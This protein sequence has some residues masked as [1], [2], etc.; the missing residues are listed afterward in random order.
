MSDAKSAGGLGFL[1]AAAVTALVLGMRLEPQPFEK[2]R[3]QER[4]SDATRRV[5]AGIEARLWEDPFAAVR[6]EDGRLAAGCEKAKMISAWCGLAGVPLNNAELLP[7][8]SSV[9]AA[10]HLLLFATMQGGQFL[11]AEEMRRR[12]RFAVL[13]GLQSAAYIPA[14]SGRVQLFKVLMASL[15]DTAPAPSTP[16]GSDE[17]GFLRVPYEHWLLDELHPSQ[18]LAPGRYRTITVFW[19]DENKLPVPRKLDALASL[20]GQVRGRLGARCDLEPASEP[21]SPSCAPRLAYWPHIALLGPSNTDA[22]Q[23]ALRDLKIRAAEGTIDDVQRKVQRAEKAASDALVALENSAAQSSDAAATQIGKTS[24]KQ[25]EAMLRKAMVEGSQQTPLYRRHLGLRRLQE[26]THVGYQLLVGA[27][28]FNAGATVQHDLVPEIGDTDD[29][30]GLVHKHLA[31]VAKQAK[32]LDA[33]L[34]TKEESNVVQPKG[35][36]QLT[37]TIATDDRL[38]KLLVQ[39]LHARIDLGKRRVVLLTERDSQYGRALAY[40]FERCLLGQSP[41]QEAGKVQPGVSPPVKVHFFR[42]LDGVTGREQGGA[43]PAAREAIKGDAPLIEWPESTAQLDYLRRV[44]QSLRASELE[45][46]KAPIGAIGVLGSDVHDKLLILQA[47][48]DSYPDKVF[49]T[50]DMDARL[51]HPQALSFTRN[52]VVASSLPLLLPERVTVR[53]PDMRMEVSLGEGVPPLRDVYQSAAYLA[54]RAASC[55]EQSCR[56]RERAALQQLLDAPALYEVGRSRAVQLDS[57]GRELQ[58]GGERFSQRLVSA[59]LLALSAVAWLWWPSTPSLRQL[60]RH[61]RNGRVQSLPDAFGRFMVVL[62]GG[63]LIYVLGTMVEFLHPGRL[64]YNLLVLACLAVMLCLA[65]WLRLRARQ[66]RAQTPA[67]VPRDAIA[68]ALLVI[69]V[70]TLALWQATGGEGCYQCEPVA[71]LEGVSA[72]PSHWLHSFALVVCL[73]ALD[74]VWHEGWRGLLR[75]QRWLHLRVAFAPH[76]G[77]STGAVAKL[78]QLSLLE[79]MRLGLLPWRP[80]ERDSRE[81][82]EAWHV[83]RLR[84]S[85][86]PRLGRLLLLYLLTLSLS[87]LAF[88][89]FSE[90]L[91]PEVPVRGADH[92]RLVSTTLYLVLLL[93]P[94]LVVAVADGTGLVRQLIAHLGQGRSI[95]P[96][97]CR[98]HFVS[99]L[100]HRH[101][102]LWLRGFHADPRE[103]ELVPDAPTAPDSGHRHTLLDDWID[104]QLVARSSARAAPLVLGPFIVLA[105][106]VLARSRVFDNWALT[107]V[108][109]VTVGVYLLWLIAVSLGLRNAAERERE[110]AL[111]S[112]QAD[113]LWL[114]GSGGRWAELIPSFEAMMQQVR[115]T[116]VGAFANVLDQPLLKAALL[117]VAGAGLSKL[118]DSLLLAQ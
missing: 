17:D 65:L 63:A 11:G 67:T 38:V 56:V 55:S 84:S 46:G 77:T 76:Q 79:T 33:V 110:N 99:A 39:E 106:M 89:L 58:L 3:P 48:H 66:S 4:V 105:L 51:L 93:F 64:N 116:R 12:M 94:L 75:D 28:F 90:G 91:M 104:I 43:T 81:V 9:D 49:F 85:G 53:N 98:E 30:S 7:D 18:H 59:L 72:W 108:I 16:I 32:R 14:D 13:S 27:R 22:L 78:R 103:R 40:S 95:Y 69:C 97:K 82:V 1:A 50:T 83:F 19:I 34:K 109:V 8:A 118:V 92:K 74:H 25:R 100:G 87:Y 71:W 10:Q 24:D 15:G 62:H 5:S 29:L 23:W 6:R 88:R 44:A 112:M 20:L 113:L 80:R 107:P 111:A 36:E 52:L 70:L 114:R 102:D 37:S 57:Q 117:P 42:G 45:D 47:L 26:D 86:W 21:G 35:D 60:R 41:C 2:L 54:A 101:R 73:V 68:L 61:L 115:E 31:E 96:E